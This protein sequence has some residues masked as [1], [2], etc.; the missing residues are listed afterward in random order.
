[1]EMLKNA[2]EIEFDRTYKTNK[3]PY[4]AIATHIKSRGARASNLQKARD[5]STHN[6]GLLSNAKASKADAILNRLGSEGRAA[7]ET[8]RK[9]SKKDSIN[10]GK[11]IRILKGMGHK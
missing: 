8:D 10:A 9:A 2:A 5:S 7:S 1:M 11:Q 6:S 4:G 3:M